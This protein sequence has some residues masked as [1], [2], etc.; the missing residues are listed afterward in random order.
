MRRFAWFL[1]PSILCLPFTARADNA[2]EQL[3]AASAYFDHHKYSAAAETL[4]A[5]VTQHP[6]H[7]RFGAAAFTL[8]RCRVELKQYDQA[9][10]AFQKAIGSHD[11]SV[12]PLAQLGLGE[13]AMNAHKYDVAAPALEAA[14]KTDLKPEQA[15]IVWYWLGQADFR[16]K[17]YEPAEAAYHKVVTDYG[18]TEYAP[19]AAYGEA[20]AALRQKKLDTARQELSD[21]VS[22][23][24][25]SPDRPQARLLL[26]QMDLDAKRYSDASSALEALLGDLSGTKANAKLAAQTE[27]SLIQ[28]LLEQGDYAAAAPHLHAALDRLSATD[29]QRF[30]ADLSLGHCEYRQ[31]HYLPAVAAYHEAVQSPERPVAAEAMYWEANALLGAGKPTEA[32]TQF[33]QF[34]AQFPKDK[35]AAHAEL[36]AGDALLAAKQNEHA[37]LTYQ[38]VIAHDAGTKDAADARKGLATALDRISDPDRLA[39]VLT[40]TTGPEKAH[41]VVRLARLDLARKRFADAEEELKAF[42]S[43]GSEGARG[44]E[45]R[46]LLGV[47]YDA[48]HKSAPALQEL[49]E[50]VRQTS[51]AF[52]LAD[53]Q[54]RLAWLYI[55]AKHPDQAEQAA[56]AALSA[57][58]TAAM[59][60]QARLARVQALIDQKKWEPA[61]QGCQELME[62]DPAPKTA[63]TALYTQ[64]WINEKRGAT[65]AALPIW[66]RLAADYPKS[67]YTAEALLHLGD[68]RMKAEKYQEAYEKFSTLL[69]TLPQSRLVPEA[70]FKMGSALFNLNRPDDAAAEFDAVVASKSA[71]ALGQDALY[72]AGVA[73][74]KAGKKEAAMQRLSRLVR[75]YPQ[76]SHV[77]NAKIYLAALKAGG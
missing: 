7:P 76:N 26:A 77:S 8:G 24:P 19:A 70:H 64:A 65:N 48:Q 18:D 31:K 46:Y 45:L 35:L 25:Q 72:W 13:A 27:D 39:S 9:I 16:L 12:I 20:V 51:T 29:P 68:A 59:A 42:L 28:A 73:F 71:G 52:W 54:T 21:F 43:R 22:R 4:Q 40:A 56:N 41:G 36:R 67:D 5:F 3:A 37:A 47:S 74:N 15:P 38:A 60:Q 10:D 66:E 61:L 44:S 32:A 2:Q 69:T 63:A 33:E 53:A 23:Y 17:K 30:R 34:A 62:N 57:Q 11:A 6:T 55:G 58:P 49:A 50:A 1:I 14:V 75:D